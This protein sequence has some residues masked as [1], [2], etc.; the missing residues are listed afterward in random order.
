VH[1]ELKLTYFESMYSSKQL[2]YSRIQWRIQL[3][4]L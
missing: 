3:F 4:G 1:F 2:W